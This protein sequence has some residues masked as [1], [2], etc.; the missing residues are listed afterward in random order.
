MNDNKKNT[1]TPVTEPDVKTVDPA[2]V[3]AAKAAEILRHDQQQRLAAFQQAI[4][5]AGQKYRC[6]LSAVIIL[7]D[8]QLP[9]SRIEAQAQP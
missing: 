5:E 1:K 6:T 2:S 7:R 3:D 8:G 4:T 9:V